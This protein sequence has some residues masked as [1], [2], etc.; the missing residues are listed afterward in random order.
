MK[1]TDYVICMTTKGGREW[2]YF[3]EGTVWTQ[4][5]PEGQA[6]RM[7]AEQVLNHLLPAIAGIKPLSVK[8]VHRPSV[9]SQGAGAEF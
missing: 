1:N 8:I 4:V 5:G 9:E 2:K 3:K 6:H 7:T